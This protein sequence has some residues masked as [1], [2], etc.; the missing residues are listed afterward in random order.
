VKTEIKY[1]Q[2][3]Y[4]EFVALKSRLFQGGMFV[5]IEDND[6][7]LPRYN[8]LLGFFCPQFRND[9]WVNPMPAK[10]GVYDAR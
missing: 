1:V 9:E 2:D 10:A 4:Q 6:P 3:L 8:Q 5:C 7:D